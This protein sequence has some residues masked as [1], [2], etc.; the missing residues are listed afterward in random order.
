M[1]T[2]PTL[3]PGGC[4]WWV[5]WLIPSVPSVPWG[6]LEHYSICS[7]NA[8]PL[9]VIGMQSPLSCQIYFPVLCLHLLLLYFWMTYHSC[10]L[11]ASCW[12]SEKTYFSRPQLS[13][14]WWLRGRNTQTSS[15]WA[16]GVL[17]FLMEFIWSCPPLMWHALVGSQCGMSGLGWLLSVCFCFS[18]VNCCSCYHCT[19]AFSQFQFW[20]WINKVFDK[21]NPELILEIKGTI[22]IINHNIS[23]GLGYKEFA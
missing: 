22:L 13:R 17:H 14:S 12:A 21:N 7:G 16:T 4:I 2:E 18:A 20:F 5:S 8:H 11:Q 6:L 15:L 9:H 3:L 23:L 1:F 10:R 19:F